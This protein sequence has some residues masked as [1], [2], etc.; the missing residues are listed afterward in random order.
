MRYMLAFSLSRAKQS[1]ER[2][3]LSQVNI[4][5]LLGNE[6][7]TSDSSVG[8]LRQCING[9]YFLLSQFVTRLL[10]ERKQATD[11][12]ITLIKE[13]ATQMG[14]NAFKGWAHELQM[15]TYLQQCSEGT[16]GSKTFQITLQSA[17][18]CRKELAIKLKG[19]FFFYELSDIGHGLNSDK[20]LLL[21]QKFNQG[22]YDAVVALLK[23]HGEEE[24]DVLLLLQA[25]VGKK[26]SFKPQFITKLLLQLAV[27]TSG[28]GEESDTG[29]EESGDEERTRSAKRLKVEERSESGQQKDV[30]KAADILVNRLCIW[31]CFVL[32]TEEQLRNFRFP[33]SQPVGM[34]SSFQRWE[35]EPVFWKA[36]LRKPT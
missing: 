1:I 21:P 6:D 13:K 19:E 28:K 2:A 22:C 33:K 26:H 23:G 20:V 29:G 25:T 17:D 3:F 8:A 4:Q 14:N 15:L 27:N 32:E 7:S 30:E 10:F 31:H 12:I 35:I 36:V 18:D 11:S 24:K 16:P 34:R 5:G 9:K